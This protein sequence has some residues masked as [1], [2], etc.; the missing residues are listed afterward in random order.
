M[1]VSDDPTLLLSLSLIGRCSVI[2]SYNDTG[3]R[4]VPGVHR[5]G[6]KLAFISTIVQ[7]LT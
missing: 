1:P 2:I 7:V 5:P 4:G 3:I 6:A